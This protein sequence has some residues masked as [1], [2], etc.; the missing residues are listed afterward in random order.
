MRADCW[1]TRATAWSSSRPY[2]STQWPGLIVAPLNALI[3]AGCVQSLA[4][5][6]QVVPRESAACP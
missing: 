3:L 1:Y 6:W 4:P 5:S 2:R